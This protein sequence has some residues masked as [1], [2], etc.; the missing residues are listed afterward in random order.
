MLKC[1]L[2]IQF[3]SPCFWERAA[4]LPPIV[5]AVTIFIGFLLPIVASLERLTFY[6]YL[7]VYLP[8][9][10]LPF[11]FI[12]LFIHSTAIWLPFTWLLCAAA[13][14]GFCHLNDLRL[15]VYNSLWQILYF[16]LEVAYATETVTA[17]K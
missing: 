4:Q 11:L 7:F 9:C 3:V 6:W 13:L 10:W 1:Q 15:F 2:K 5:V 8:G 14:F 12:H 17:L 16:S